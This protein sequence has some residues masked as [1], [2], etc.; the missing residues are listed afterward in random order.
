[1]CSPEKSIEILAPAGSFEALEAALDAGATAVYLGLK[2]LNARRGARNFDQDEFIR[3][4]QTAHARGARVYLTLN[5]DLTQRELGQAARMLELARQ[6]HADAV[7]VRDPS[8][9]ALRPY[10]PELEFHFSTQACISSSADAAAAGQLGI[11][12]VVL[13]RELS[14]NEIASASVVP[15]VQTEIFAQ[16][17]LCFCISGRCLLSSWVGGRSGNRGACT[18][19]CRVPW[20][21]NNSP[22][23]TPLSM[24]DLST[25]HRIDDLRKAGVVS[26]KIEGRLKSP[27]WVAKA[28]SL[29]RR[30]LAGA[31]PATLAQEAAELG[32]YTGRTMTCGYLDGQRDQL[33][34]IAEG[35]VSTTAP[36][37]SS[38]PT[39]EPRAEAPS[40]SYELQISVE[41]RG[42]VC[43]CGKGTRTV[44]WT[45]PKTLVRRENKAISIGQFLSQLPAEPVRGLRLSQANTNSPDFLLVPRAANA[46]S[47]R[48][49]TV[50]R[51]LSRAEEAEDDLIRI[52]LPEPVRN[53]VAPGTRSESNDLMLGDHPDRVRLHASGVGSF[54]KRIRATGSF[55]ARPDAIVV[56]G[57]VAANVQKVHAQC[58]DIPMIVALP[59]VFFEDELTSIRQLL[60]AC[61]N[62]GLCVEVNSWGGWHLARQAGLS[63]ESGPG[64]PVLNA[65]AARELAELGIQCVTLSIEADR[66]Q[67]EELTGHCPVPCSM[68]IFGRPTLMTTRVQFDR[69]RFLNRTLTD[70]RGVRAVAHQ[71]R[72]LWMLRSPEP[73][74]LRASRNDRIRVHHLVMDLVTS[75]DPASEWLLPPQP[76]DRPF[77]FNYNRTLA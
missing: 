7:L 69:E 22:A 16:G 43:R 12:R 53:L 1:M 23:G 6:A 14:L 8:L 45:M 33:T 63:M 38:P 5:I 21:L 46:L 17:A 40:P 29:Y 73:F 44:E 70:R 9:L 39:P 48:L 2:S 27:A 74:D 37:P 47:N 32:A 76:E 72:N 58:A 15:G 18:S 20:N 54:L 11:A 10:Y 59:N 36:A 61:A 55:D 28:V 60:A 19:P 49:C 35:R 26:L 67:L 42:I 4:V 68:I 31:D 75:R 13:A 50:L 62:S 41:E 57:L 3:A 51:Q 66:K 56:E 65:L 77:R 52:E 30:A 71:E 64:I 25:A 24:R 34:A